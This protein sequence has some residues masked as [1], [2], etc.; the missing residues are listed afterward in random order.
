[1]VIVLLVFLIMLKIES[2]V[3]SNK[4]IKSQAKTVSSCGIWSIGVIWVGN[5]LN[6]IPNY[7]S[8]FQ[9]TSAIACLVLMILVCVFS[10]KL[11]KEAQAKSN[12]KKVIEVDDEIDSIEEF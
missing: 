4:K 3:I 12:E 10:S 2:N 6:I 5:I 8:Y 11:I 7:G 9:Y 1:M